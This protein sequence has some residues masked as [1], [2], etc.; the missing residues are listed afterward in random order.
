MPS[1]H[2]EQIFTF[3]ALCASICENGG[4]CTAPNT[5]EC[6]DGYSGNH[7][8]AGMVLIFLF[9][10]H[11]HLHCTLLSQPYVPMLVKM[12]EVVLHQIPVSVQTDIQAHNV[13]QVRSST[14]LRHYSYYILH[15][16]P[17]V[18]QFV[19]IKELVLHQ[20]PVSVVMDMQAT[21]VKQVW[22]R[23]FYSMNIVAISETD[24]SLQ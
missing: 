15:F 21:N 12:E 2:R 22:F 13:K 14:S 19:K 3:L 1:L 8:Q 7:C 24:F 11:A 9:H 4:T 17:Y 18:T 5:C 16:Q 6:V 20:I 10:E 23:H